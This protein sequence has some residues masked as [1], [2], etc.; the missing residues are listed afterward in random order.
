MVASF[1]NISTWHKFMIAYHKCKTT[2]HLPQN[3][4]NV[5]NVN[6]DINSRKV[7]F[8]FVDCVRK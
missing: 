7:S 3:M 4:K 6:S 8:F 5:L 2:A 1:H